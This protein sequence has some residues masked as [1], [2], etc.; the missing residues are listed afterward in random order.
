[1]RVAHGET[2]RFPR[3]WLHSPPC[4]PARQCRPDGDWL[5]RNAVLGFAFWWLAVRLFAPAAVRPGTQSA[6][7]AVM[8]FVGLFGEAGLGTLLL[9]EI[10]LIG[11]NAS[12]L[13]IAGSLAGTF[14]TL[15]LAVPT[16]LV[17]AAHGWT[18]T[19][20]TVLFVLG[21]VLQGLA[22][23][24]DQAFMGLLR[25]NLFLA[26]NVSFALAKLVLLAV[27]ATLSRNQIVILA[28]WVTGIAASEAGVCL[29]AWRRAIITLAAPSIRP[30][31]RH[32]RTV[33][34][35]HALNLA[36]SAP[37]LLLPVVVNLCL[38]PTVNAAF[39]V[40]WMIFVV[41]T[42]VPASLTAVLFSMGGAWPSDLPRQ[43]RFSFAASIGFALAA[44]VL[45]PLF[46]EPI[47][48]L[49]NPS[50]PALAASAM[51]LLGLGLLGTGIKQHYILL[52]RRCA[53]IGGSLG[54]VVLT[55][56]WLTALTL[57]RRLNS[58]RA[59]AIGLLF[60]EHLGRALYFSHPSRSIS[61]ANCGLGTL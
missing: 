8:N 3:L 32:L 9:G 25:S 55:V 10:Q 17:M 40:G 12:P 35:H 22:L 47:L 6:V 39:S 13:I 36:A 60:I 50:F 41:A 20:A 11:A 61:F 51:A 4:R 23:V 37:Q 19:A 26:R 59:V 58:V 14:T 18:D 53:A 43:L 21:C 29:H 44:S 38:G 16:A 49:F 27:L 7:I 15:L 24:L 42:L 52:A 31:A 30:L 46:A 28:T 57:S 2:S 54:N 45:M 5:R 48:A 34:D 1:M 33:R 56:C